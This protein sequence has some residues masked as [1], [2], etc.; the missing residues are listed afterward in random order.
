L[1]DDVLD[2]QMIFRQQEHRDLSCYRIGSTELRFQTRAEVH[3]PV[4]LASM[5][6]KYLRELSMALF[7]RYWADQVPGI[8]PTAGYPVDSYRFR[9]D[10]AD[11]QRRLDIPDDLVWRE[12]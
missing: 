7:N 1:I 8:K 6:A 3:F 10:I 9:E 12:R 5:V 4:A 2:G 11:A